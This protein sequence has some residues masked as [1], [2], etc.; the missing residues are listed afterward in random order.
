MEKRLFRK[1]GYAGYFTGSILPHTLPAVDSNRYTK[2]VYTIG[3]IIPTV[4]SQ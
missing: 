3:S 4:L 1:N 2:R